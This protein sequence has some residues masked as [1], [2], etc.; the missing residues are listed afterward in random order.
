MDI[1]KKRLV[2]H[3]HKYL[4]QILYHIL[5]LYIFYF[6]NTY[7]TFCK[8]LTFTNRKFTMSSFYLC[9]WTLHTEGSN[10]VDDTKDVGHEG[11]H[12]GGGSSGKGGGD[13]GHGE[14]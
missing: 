3:A 8:Y 14:N 2:V 12:Y 6:K 11:G 7:N 4:C 13:K 1:E 10:Q 9:K 5:Y